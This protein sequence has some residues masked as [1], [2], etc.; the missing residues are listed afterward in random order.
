ML[1]KAEIKKMLTVRGGLWILL[2]CLAAKLL[3]L[4]VFP[5]MKDPRIRLSQYRYDKML[6]TLSGES[7]PEK[8]AWAARRYAQCVE[9]IA[10][11]EDVEARYRDG[12]LTEAE[13]QEY[14]EE[15]EQA[16]LDRNAAQIFSEKAQQFAAQPASLPPAHYIYEYGWQTVFTLQRF[17]D[18]FLLAGLL[19]LSARSFPSEDA[20]GMLPVLLAAKN[21]RMRLFLAKLLSLLFASFTA[22]LVFSAGEIA[23]FWLR[24]WCVSAD[25]PLHSVSVLTECRLGVS[26]AA[27]Y[28]LSAAIRILA[29][30]LFSAA[31][32][33]VSVWV[34]DAART[35]FFG[36]CL[37]LSPLLPAG[38]VVLFTHG[39]LLCGTQTL[40]GLGGDLSAAVP[41]LLVAAYTA[42]AVLLAARRYA[43][44]DM[45]L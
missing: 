32:F 45:D 33:A 17:P 10:S 11:Q 20:A 26:L 14:A 6:E 28:A 37:L 21:G 27:G 23:V 24:G 41:L 36:M 31:V 35:A 40:L 4:G 16:Y 19:L 8:N 25:A 5:E 15:L 38:S 7:S 34:R 13:H 3:F 12:L 44:G 29:S 42:L 39:G 1:V 43:R 2:L 30:V 22:A 9:T 18:V